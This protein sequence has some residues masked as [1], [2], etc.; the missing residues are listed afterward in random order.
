MVLLS[1]IRCSCITILWVSLASF[2]AITFCV[3]SRRV[4]V[5]AVVVVYFVIDSVRKLWIH[6][7]MLIS[8]PSRLRV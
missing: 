7:R 3:A 5:L 6:P 2:A 1:A 8:L 4:F